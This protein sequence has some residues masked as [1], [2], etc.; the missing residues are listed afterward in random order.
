MRRMERVLGCMLALVAVACDSQDEGVVTS[1]PSAAPRVSQATTATS[2]AAPSRSAE[3][4]TPPA[5]A[6]APGAASSAQRPLR[7]DPELKRCC[8]WFHPYNTGD[9][10]RRGPMLYRGVMSK[11]L[12]LYEKGLTLAEAEPQIAKWARA[13]MPGVCQMSWV[14]KQRQRGQ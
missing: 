1:M 13:G 5:S 11:C 9:I 10:V 8:R 6:S 14:E 7:L 3:P 4:P 12:A 2:A